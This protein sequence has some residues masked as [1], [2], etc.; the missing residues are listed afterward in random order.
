M[1]KNVSQDATIWVFISLFI[2]S[3]FMLGWLIK[4]FLSTIVIGLLVTSIFN[5]LYNLLNKKLKPSISS[6][7]TCAVIFITIFI[8][9][10]FIVSAIS[11][12]AYSMYIWAKNAILSEEIRAFLENNS[13]LDKINLFLSKF[14]IQ[15]SIE[16]LK[17]GITYLGKT[18]GLFLYKQ[19]S[20]IASNL[21]AFFINFF[22]MLL[23]VFFLLIDNKKLI[24]FIYELSPL[25]KKQNEKILQRFKEMSSA[26]L[27]GNGISGL[28]QGIAGGILFALAGFDSYILWGIIMSILAFMPI[29]GIGVVLIPASVYLFL[30]HKITQGTLVITFYIIF[31]L[32]I[33]YIVKPRIVG[34]KAQMN[35]LLIFLAIIGG[36]KLFGILGIIYGPLTATGF[37]T[38]V[39]IYKEE[40]QNIIENKS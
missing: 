36:L 1:G 27:I 15:I 12:E 9:I 10:I 26:V 20:Q 22:F 34:G 40:Y 3:F 35:T 32:G 13:I 2:I 17:N 28:I 21:F 38:F 33:E 5:P 25:P 24:E 29:I 39:S 19:A 30:I 7:I 6:F 23:I 31:S 18:T 8:P 14:H 4:P 11:T 16:D 37:L